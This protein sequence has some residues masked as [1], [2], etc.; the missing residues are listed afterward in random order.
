MDIIVNLINLMSEKFI[1]INDKVDDMLYRNIINM[2]L[3]KLDFTPKYHKIIKKDNKIIINCHS[4][5]INIFND[6]NNNDMNEEEIKL[7]TLEYSQCSVFSH[8]DNSSMPVPHY[9]NDIISN[10]DLNKCKKIKDL[11][12]CVKYADITIDL[13]NNNYKIIKSFFNIRKP[14]DDKFNL[15]EKI[16]NNIDNP[17]Y[18]FVCNY[19]LNSLN[20]SY[21][22]IKNNIYDLNAISITFI[23]NIDNNDNIIID[24]IMPSITSLSTDIDTKPLVSN[25]IKRTVFNGGFI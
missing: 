9:Y 1:M 21:S 13:D 3:S 24:V 6:I 25:Q 8:T 15:F 22:D 10:Y 2:V 11:Y 7:K 4:Y 5:F 17:S 16:I 14:Y 12:L 19:D 23:N 20:E 18:Y